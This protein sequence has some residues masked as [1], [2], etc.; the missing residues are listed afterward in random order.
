MKKKRGN[1]KYILFFIII[2]L[3]TLTVTTMAFALNEEGNPTVK[4]MLDEHET[5]VVTLLTGNSDLRG[6]NIKETIANYNDRYLLGLAADFSVFMRNDVTPYQSDTEGR[7]AVGG[8]LIIST[9]WSD[10]PTYSVG[11]GDY[12]TQ[13]PYDT[14]VRN[15]AGAA[16]IILGGELFGLLNDT[17]Y[18][19]DGTKYEADDTFDIHGNPTKVPEQKSSKRLVLNRETEPDWITE[20]NIPD[21][22]V[23]SWQ[24]V[25]KTQTYIYPLIDFDEI[26]DGPD[27]LIQTAKN[28]IEIQRTNKNTISWGEEEYTFPVYDE[29]LDEDVM[30]TAPLPIITFKYEGKSTD[31]R[32]CVYFNLSA[33]DYEHFRDA[34]VV[35]FENIPNLPKVRDVISTQGKDET[36]P[37]SYIVINVEGKG[38]IHLGNLEVADG[39]KS[40]SINGIFIS[41]K[42]GYS[43][44]AENNNTGVTSILYNFYE[45]EEI[46]IANSFQGTVFAPNADVTDEVMLI[47]NEELENAWWRDLSSWPDE[48]KEEEDWWLRAETIEDLW[49]YRGHL[50]GALIAKSFIGVTEFGYRPF[51]GPFYLMTGNLVVTKTVEGDVDPD[52]EFTFIVTVDESITGMYGD[53]EF[54][55]G[56]ATFKLKHGESITATDL[57]A[58]LKYTVTE[59]NEIGYYAKSSVNAVGEILEAETIEVEYVNVSLG[60]V[61]P[62][63]VDII[64][65]VII[66]FITALGTIIALSSFKK[67]KYVNVK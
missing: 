58:E 47:V 67:H 53:M 41:D 25:D 5:D 15:R 40:T 59:E 66:L 31:K 52:K 64:V 39:S 36:W 62:N 8:D 22:Y 48:W 30:V 12:W 6:K 28:L 20:E 46:V 21:G 19:E 16:T 55:D 29:D 63:T 2:G 57:P 51:T 11:V 45:A 50:S 3:I 56:V 23:G 38:T 43:T 9:Y 44:M 1:L 35:K 18:G 24:K 17:Y 14:L 26:Y 4:S 33:E 60:M 49:Y 37:Y 13:I 34:A 27:G 32:D 61:M 7:L 10:P 42:P 54:V 65:L